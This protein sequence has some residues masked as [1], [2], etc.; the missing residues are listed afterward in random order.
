[1]YQA[2]KQAIASRQIRVTQT[3]VS[4]NSWNGLKQTLIERGVYLCACEGSVASYC[5]ETR[6]EIRAADGR[7]LPAVPLGIRFWASPLDQPPRYI[8]ARE[9]STPGPG[10]VIYEY[11]DELAQLMRGRDFLMFYD[12]IPLPSYLTQEELDN[13]VVRKHP[14]IF[15]AVYTAKNPST[16]LGRPVLTPAGITPLTPP[17]TNLCHC[18][19]WKC[20][21]LN[22]TVHDQHRKDV[23]LLKWELQLTQ[24]HGELYVIL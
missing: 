14:N 1:M 3:K 20:S 4:Y 6:E 7:L 15:F 17:G 10:Q 24:R 22:K 8:S 13:H 19:I 2:N 18:V 11:S 12:N 9:A 5:V 16:H 23:Q 21:L